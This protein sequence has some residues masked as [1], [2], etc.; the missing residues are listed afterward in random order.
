MPGPPPPPPPPPM[1]SLSSGGPPPPPPPPMMGGGPAPPPP[2]SNLFGNSNGNARADLLKSIADPSKPRLKKV[3]P[4]LIKDRSKPTVA[5]SNTN[6]SSS[7][8]ISNGSSN[9]N[10]QSGSENK[11]NLFCFFFWSP[12]STTYI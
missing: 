11:S 8:N 7:N 1:P 3:D 6:N 10:A 2:P 4:S 5:G 12:I 9:S